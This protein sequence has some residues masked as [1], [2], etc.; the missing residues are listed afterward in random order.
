MVDLAQQLY[1]NLISVDRVGVDDVFKRTVTET[2]IEGVGEI[3]MEAMI[4]LGEGWESGE[5]SLAQVYMSGVI[6]DELLN[7]IMH[8]ENTI[9]E[10][11][12]IIGTAVYIDHHSLGMKIV[13]NLV[14]TGQYPLINI[15]VGVDADEIIKQIHEKKIQILLISVLMY[16]SALEVKAL[17]ER[18]CRE[19]P[20]V[21]IVVGGAPFR[22][23][24]ELYKKV[25]AH[26]SAGNAGEIFGILHDLK[27]EIYSGEF[28]K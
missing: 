23:D 28:L 8:N 24:K 5:V 2:G 11:L 3:L 15:G 19:C 21:S 7:S 25:G 12:P 18:V 9:D 6:C 1:K 20:A 26:R 27:K 14:R 22:L 4:K 17:S 16:P 10:N 13:S